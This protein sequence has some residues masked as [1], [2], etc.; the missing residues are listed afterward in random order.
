[1]AERSVSDPQK[2]RKTLTKTHS[3]KGAIGLLYNE[4]RKLRNR[5]SHAGMTP[6][7][8]HVPDLTKVIALI[9]RCRELSAVDH[10]DWLA[11]L[12]IT[13]TADGDDV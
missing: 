1:M 7:P 12:P 13:E 4:I 11:A 10:D 3:G 2:A 9:E 5:L 8:V 6:K